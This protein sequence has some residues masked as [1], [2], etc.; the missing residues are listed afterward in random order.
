M[1]NSL[2][3]YGS[4]MFS[5]V[6]H[7]V[8]GRTFSGCSAS[9][10]GYARFLVRGEHYPGIVPFCQMRTTGMLYRAVPHHTLTCLDRFE[11]AL[12][13]RQNVRIRLFNG[14]RVWAYAYVIRPSS[15][16]ILSTHPFEPETFF[17]QHLE[18]FLNTYRP[19]R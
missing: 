17:N 9:I 1:T 6:M 11:G 8:T 4:L 2:F 12:Y 3:V 16:H 13:K 15:R 7:H 14:S 5:Q 19:Y 18:K 10:E